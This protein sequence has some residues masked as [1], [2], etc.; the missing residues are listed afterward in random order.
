MNVGIQIA[1]THEHLKIVENE[2][3]FPEQAFSS[4][5]I[6]RDPPDRILEEENPLNYEQEGLMTRL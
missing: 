5:R 3:A 2:D 1:G 6:D 4:W